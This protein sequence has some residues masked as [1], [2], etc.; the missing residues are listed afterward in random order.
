MIS[1]TLLESSER[2]RHFVDSIPRGESRFIKY[3]CNNINFIGAIRGNDD[4]AGYYDN[5]EWVIDAT[6]A[7]HY[8][9]GRKSVSKE[10]LIKIMQMSYRD[11]FQYLL[12]HPEWLRW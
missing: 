12:F 11:H 9:V 8:G 2:L 6:A 5:Y 3:S 10:E 4:G 1:P 7:N